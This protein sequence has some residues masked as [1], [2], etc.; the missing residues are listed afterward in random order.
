MLNAITTNQLV[1]IQTNLCIHLSYCLGQLGEY[2]DPHTASSVF[3]ILVF[4]HNWPSTLAPKRHF[5][6]KVTHTC[7]LR[8]VYGMY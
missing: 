5:R 4:T 1:H 6:A 7:T 2:C 3:L 8:F